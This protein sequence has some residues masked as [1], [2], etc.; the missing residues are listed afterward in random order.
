MPPFNKR[1]RRAPPVGFVEACLPSAVDRIPVRGE[2]LHE[3][4]YDGYRL[5]ARKDASGVRSSRGAATT[6]LIAFRS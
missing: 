2:W 1:A 4:K 5:Q 3:I 6:G